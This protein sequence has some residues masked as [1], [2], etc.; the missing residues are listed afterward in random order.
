[1]KNLLVVVESGE[2]AINFVAAIIIALKVNSG[3]LVRQMCQDMNFH[4]GSRVCD[5]F[6]VVCEIER[7]LVK[8]K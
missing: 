6:A 8:V 2:R 3:V 7:D 4:V 5:E 1:M